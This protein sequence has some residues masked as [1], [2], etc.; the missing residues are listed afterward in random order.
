MAFPLLLS[1]Q[2]LSPSLVFYFGFSSDPS[3]KMSSVYGA[4]LI[5][6]EDSEKE[7]ILFK[8]KNNTE[9]TYGDNYWCCD[10]QIVQAVWTLVPMCGLD[11]G[12]SFMAL[13][14]DFISRVGIGNPHSVVFHLPG[15]S[16]QTHV[17]RPLNPDN[18]TEISFRMDTGISE[19]LLISLMRLLKK[20]LIDDSVK[21]ID[22]TSQTIRVSS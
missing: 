8:R 19:E 1:F 16:G 22:M 15:D 9:D 7:I 14:S 18:S 11:D 13:V 21:I 10:N 4:R 3:H 2:W 12:N 6:F 20:Y 17:C 5:T